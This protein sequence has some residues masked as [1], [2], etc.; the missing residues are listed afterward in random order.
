MYHLPL[1]HG[2]GPASNIRSSV[3]PSTTAVPDDAINIVSEAE[4]AGYVSSLPATPAQGNGFVAPAPSSAPPTL[5]GTQGT[6]TSAPSQEHLPPI[7]SGI[8]LNVTYQQS[9]SAQPSDTRPQRRDDAGKDE[10][11]AEAVFFSYGVVVFFGLEEGQEK[12]ILEDVEAAGIATRKMD[13]E[14]W[15]VEECHYTVSGLTLPSSS[16]LV[17]CCLSIFHAVRRIYRI[18]KNLQRFLQ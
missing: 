10:E 6:S 8:E 1:L 14:N 7:S 2:Y 16:F 9:Q 17:W 18:P 4:D 15:E 3:A 5:D 12:G 13:E 11:F